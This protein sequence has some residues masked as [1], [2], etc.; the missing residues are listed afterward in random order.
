[1]RVNTVNRVVLFRNF[2]HFILR[3]FLLCYSV[4]SL[5][6]I[7]FETGSLDG[8]VVLELS[9]YFFQRARKLAQDPHTPTLSQVVTSRLP[10]PTHISRP[11]HL[12]HA[13]SSEAS[14]LDRLS[15]P[16]VQASGDAKQVLAPFG[17]SP[18]WP[19][20]DD[21]ICDGHDVIVLYVPQPAP[22][23]HPCRRDCCDRPGRSG[24]P[25]RG[26]QLRNGHPNHLSW[27]AA[28]HARC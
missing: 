20:E 13:S 1:M 23:G 12:H 3:R 19:D 16:Q 26:L 10:T 17:R 25:R 9:Q 21:S 15:S 6:A 2:L 24:H 11:L 7:F 18:G 27:P 5:C 14:C 4:T 22:C 28:N 8:F